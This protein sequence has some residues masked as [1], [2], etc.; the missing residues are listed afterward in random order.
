MPRPTHDIP[1]VVVCFDD[2]PVEDFAAAV[3]PWLIEALQYACEG[4]PTEDSIPELKQR[5]SDYSAFLVFLAAAE[6]K[7]KK[8]FQERV[9]AELEQ[10]VA[11]PPSVAREIAEGRAGFEL[12][13]LTKIEEAAHA[14][15]Q[16]LITLNSRMA[17]E[18][19]AGGVTEPPPF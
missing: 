5:Q 12:D 16:S 15:T 2:A 6:G 14:L 7:A 9:A 19:A 3:L 13:L 4:F 18:R 17:T 8:C 10:L 1:R 11:Y